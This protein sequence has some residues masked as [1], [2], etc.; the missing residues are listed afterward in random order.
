MKGAPGAG[1]PNPECATFKPRDESHVDPD[2][3]YSVGSVISYGKFRTINL[4]DFTY[5]AEQDLM[6]PNNP[7]GT[8][9]LYLTSHHGIDQSG[10]PALVHALHPRVAVMHNSTRKGGAVPTM[11]T[12]FSSP[13]LEDVWQLH[14]AYAAGM[15]LNA[16]GL[17]IANIEDPKTLADVLQNPPPTFGQAGARGPGAPGGRGAGSGR[18]MAGGH[19]GPAFYIK[20]AAEADGTFT[21]TNTRNGFSKTYAT[22][23]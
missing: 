7:I 21:V 13:G 2:N 10:S 18:G 11:Q 14:W 20:V 3:R 16:P 5:N 15:E 19:T 6:C 8:V 22:R 4:G 23:K 9:D 17:F 1:K 12:L